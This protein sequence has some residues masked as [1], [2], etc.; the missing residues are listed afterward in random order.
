MDNPIMISLLVLLAGV[1]MSAFLA[2]IRA[3]FEGP[4]SAIEDELSQSIGRAFMIGFVNTLFIGTLVTALLFVLE[5]VNFRILSIPTI[6]LVFILVL[7]FGC[8]A[9]LGLT[10]VT[11]HIGRKFFPDRSWF[12]QSTIG[13]FT[14][15]IACALPFLGWYGL[16]PLLIITGVGG[17][18]SK[19]FK[20]PQSQ[21][22]DL[23]EQPDAD[24]EDSEVLLAS[25]RD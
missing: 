8:A 24:G 7:V 17:F 3:F 4:V 16:F 23:E 22:E 12:Y 2:V 5:N 10:G 1:S 18:I 13:S 11:L 14:V 25:E 19:F 21:Y 20:K 6:I 9:I 15:F